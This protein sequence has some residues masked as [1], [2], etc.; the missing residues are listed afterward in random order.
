[1]RYWMRWLSGKA[2]ASKSSHGRAGE[3]VDV[4]IGLVVG[5]VALGMLVGALVAPEDSD[6]AGFGA[7]L[8][9]ITSQAT[10]ADE[11]IAT[12]SSR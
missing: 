11:A 1:M 9:D 8:S 10:G 6:E 2:P 7:W 5:A 3:A 12:D 4:P